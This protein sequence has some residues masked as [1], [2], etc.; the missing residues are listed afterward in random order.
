M[1]LHHVLVL[2]GNILAV[3]LGGFFGSAS[4]VSFIVEASTPFVSLRAILAEHKREDTLLYKINAVMMTFSFFIF[5][6]CFY[7]YMVFWKCQDLLMYRH[8]SFW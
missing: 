3:W 6:V 5:R 2:A 7:Y 8:V 4:Q 1:Y